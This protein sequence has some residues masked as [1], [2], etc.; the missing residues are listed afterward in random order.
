MIIE[1]FLKSVADSHAQTLYSNDSDNAINVY[2]IV[3]ANIPGASYSSLSK[4]LYDSVASG[5]F[6]EYLTEYGDIYGAYELAGCTSSASSLSMH[7][8]DAETNEKDDNDVNNMLSD[9]VIAAIVIGICLTAAFIVIGCV[10]RFRI[11]NCSCGRTTDK[12]SL[13]SETATC[14]DDQRNKESTTGNA[15]QHVA[16]GGIELFP[17][18]GD[19]IHERI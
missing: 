8:M 7:S 11:M 10:Y 16:G 5:A 14:C 19:N 17:R 6:N 13:Q 2:Y 3:N 1:L 12:L 9:T 4:K 15:P 18:T